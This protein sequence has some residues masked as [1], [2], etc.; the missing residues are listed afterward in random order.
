MDFRLPEITSDIEYFSSGELSYGF[1]INGD[2]RV[3]YHPLVPT[4]HGH[5]TVDPIYVDIEAVETA[6][7]TEEII[8][9]MR[10]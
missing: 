9:S 8:D 7:G 10:K 1:I 2:G 5:Y 6:P 4:P 3:V